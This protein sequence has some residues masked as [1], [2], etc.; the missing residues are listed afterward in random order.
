L[1]EWECLERLLYDCR[2][3][4][5]HRPLLGTQL[6]VIGKINTLR[7][8][9]SVERVFAPPLTTPKLV[10]TTAHG[11]TEKPGSNRLAAEAMYGAKGIEEGVL[12]GVRRVIRVSHESVGEAVNGTLV[13][14]YEAVES[15]NVAIPSTGEDRCVVEMP[16]CAHRNL[17]R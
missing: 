11:N 8:R 9:V 4:G 6:R 15:I 13:F 1:L 5:P 17:S 2:G 14:E 7:I 16:G 10:V 3:L 12:S